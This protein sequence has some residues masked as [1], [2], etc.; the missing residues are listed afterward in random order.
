MLRPAAYRP[1]ILSSIPST[2]VWP[3]LTSCGGCSDPLARLCLLHK[4]R[5]AV[6]SAPSIRSISLIFSSFISPGI[7]KQV[8]G[9]LNA[10]KKLIQNFFG[11]RHYTSFG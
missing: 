3:F 1:T 8:F 6:S 5:C 2:R 4:P 11:H 10:L 9:A 7:A